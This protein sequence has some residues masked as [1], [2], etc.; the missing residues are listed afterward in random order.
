[1]KWAVTQWGLMIITITVI[2]ES[3][4]PLRAAIRAQAYELRSTHL[5]SILKGKK[6]KGLAANL[7]SPE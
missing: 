6:R 1:M 2:G 3:C 5:I 7:F 4:L